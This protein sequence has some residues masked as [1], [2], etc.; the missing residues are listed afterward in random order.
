MNQ[1]SVAKIGK[2]VFVAIAKRR[3]EIGVSG[4]PVCDE[5]IV[6]GFWKFSQNDLQKAQECELLIAIDKSC[7]VG[8]WRIRQNSWRQGYN[9][10]IASRLPCTDVV[11]RYWC[12]TQGA[13]TGFAVGSRIDG[14]CD[15]GPMS[16]RAYLFNF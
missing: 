3:G 2:A 5:D 1:Y 9:G 13:F 6:R 4:R 7:I 8:A 16:G 11:N 15:P 12:T 14:P 10:A